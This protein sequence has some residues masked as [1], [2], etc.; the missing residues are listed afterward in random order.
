MS[1]PTLLPLVASRTAMPRVY[2]IGP[3]FTVPL[4]QRNCYLR[5]AAAVALLLFAGLRLSNLYG[6]PQPWAVQD[7]GPLYTALSFVNITKYPPS[8]LFLSLTLGVA[9]LLLSVAEGV[10]ARLRGW[11]SAFGRVPMFYYL[12]HLILI[13]GGAVRWTWVKFGQPYNLAFSPPAY[14]RPLRTSPACCGLTWYGLW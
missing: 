3:W 13:S 6:D 7:R 5:L 10:P 1:E 9:L 2:A 8:L 11:L 4:A 14:R 12:C